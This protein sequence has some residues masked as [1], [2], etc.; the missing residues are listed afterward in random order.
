MNTHFTV[1]EENMIS[2]YAEESREK[3]A[4]NILVAIPHMDEDMRRLADTVICK[5]EVMS[6]SDFSKAQFSLTDE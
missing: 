1:E 2:I 4:E 5:L 3:T 6:D